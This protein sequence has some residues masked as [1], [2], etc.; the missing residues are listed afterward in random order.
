[1]ALEMHRVLLEEISAFN[2]LDA[3]DLFFQFRSN[4]KR[5]GFTGSIV[6]FQMRL[7][8]AEAPRFGDDPNRALTRVAF[9]EANTHSAM[10]TMQ[11]E[12]HKKLWAKRVEA[13]RLT[14]AR[15]L[16]FLKVSS[17]EVEQTL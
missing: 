16:Y 10:E 3:P 7:I 2:E 15:I 11:S 8:H 17:W 12:E 9:L 1:M 13:V 6:P 4:Y 5:L 14:K